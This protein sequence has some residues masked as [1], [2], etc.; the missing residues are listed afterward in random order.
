MAWVRGTYILTHLG[1]RMRH[2][3]ANDLQGRTSRSI[4]A[5][6]SSAAYLVGSDPVRES[7]F[8]AISGDSAHN[9][10]RK[11]GFEGDEQVQDSN[12]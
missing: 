9:K 10:I 7:L 6:R 8:D 3:I 4:H 2:Q 11:S 1:V 5:D 12:L